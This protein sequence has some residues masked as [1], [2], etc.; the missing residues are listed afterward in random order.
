MTK[1]LINSVSGEIEIP[2]TGITIGVSG[3]YEIPPQDYLLWDASLDVIEPI[4]SGY[5]TVNDGYVNLSANDGL[6]F[7]RYPDRPAIQ[8]SDADIV[9]VARILNFI[10]SV[11]VTNDGD[12]KATIEVLG[13]G[14]VSAE[15]MREVTYIDLG[16]GQGYND[17]SNLLF[18][19][20]VNNSISFFVDTVQ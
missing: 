20:N 5:L 2:D 18:E 11:N 16:G 10:G 17:E 19:A 4:V 13:S 1:I 12:G 15:Y 8:F 14:S 6:R 7:L 9:R 3:L